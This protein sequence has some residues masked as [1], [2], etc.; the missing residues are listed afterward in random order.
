MMGMQS[1]KQIVC[2]KTQKPCR[3]CSGERSG[4][5]CN[6]DGRSF[7]NDLD[8]CPVLVALA[9]QHVPFQLS[10]RDWMARRLG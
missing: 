7:V 2:T 1:S 8:A 9:V 6:N 4:L 3:F 5:F 10:E